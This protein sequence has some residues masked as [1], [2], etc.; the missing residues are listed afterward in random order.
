MGT[1]RTRAAVKEMAKGE[2]RRGMVVLPVS[3]R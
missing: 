3:R 1:E 2:I